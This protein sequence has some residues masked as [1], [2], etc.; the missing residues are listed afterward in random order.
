MCR[1]WLLRLEHISELEGVLAARMSDLQK[2]L[3]TAGVDVTPKD[4]AALAAGVEEL[5]S[6]G[7]ALA[8]SGP[9]KLATAP[10]QESK[11]EQLVAA[12]LPRLHQLADEVGGLGDEQGS[13]KHGSWLQAKSCWHG[14]ANIAYMAGPWLLLFGILDPVWVL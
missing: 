14:H 8:N 7:A 11:K 10:G 3:G 2:L 9:L 1:G 6:Q 12:I 5:R 4:D 13:S